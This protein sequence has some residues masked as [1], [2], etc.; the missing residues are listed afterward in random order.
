[1]LQKP[2]LMVP[3]PL[4][5]E[6]TSQGSR[7]KRLETRQPWRLLKDSCAKMK[8]LT[9]FLESSP[10]CFISLGEP[11]MEFKIRLIQSTGSPCNPCAT[12]IPSNTL[13]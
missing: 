10:F 4:P 5:S 13:I 12:R 7:G 9:L 1:M 2:T 8:K 6:I 11:Q 3:G